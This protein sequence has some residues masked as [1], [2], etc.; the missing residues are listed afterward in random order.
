MM[1]KTTIRAAL[2]QSLDARGHYLYLVRDGK[3]VLYVG[4]SI[5]PLDRLQAHLERS[6]LGQVLSRCLPMSLDWGYELY[7]LTDCLSAVEHHRPASA[8]YYRENMIADHDRITRGQ[9]M[10][11]AEDALIDHHRPYL[12]VSNAQY[13]RRLPARYKRNKRANA[14]VKLA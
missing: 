6:A 10:H 7:T 9:L 14:G 12:N 5:T 4:L 2:E 1:I 11:I 13:A 3:I 8:V